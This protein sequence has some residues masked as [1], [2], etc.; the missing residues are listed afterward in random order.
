MRRVKPNKS[1][2]ST[3]MDNFKLSRH[4]KKMKQRNVSNYMDKDYTDYAKFINLKLKGIELRNKIDKNLT[5]FGNKNLFIDDY[6][7]KNQLKKTF[8]SQMKK[9]SQSVSGKRGASRT[10]ANAQV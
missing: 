3:S 5:A 4:S 10:E 6:E 1:L 7:E 9:R 2:L 8:I